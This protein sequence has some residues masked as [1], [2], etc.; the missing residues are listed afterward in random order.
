LQTAAA[1]GSVN[2]VRFLL[3]DNAAADEV[4]PRRSSPL[5]SAIYGRAQKNVATVA[6]MLLDAGADPNV[7]ARHNGGPVLHRAVANGDIDTTRLL[8]DRGADPNAQDPVGKTPIHHAVAKNQK[9]VKLLLAHSCDTTIQSNA[10]ETPMDTA[11]RLKKK[12]VIA[13]LTD[14]GRERRRM[15]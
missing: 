7:D 5:A 8:L 13:I 4:T 1:A 15:I 10:G 11:R 14:L 3:E 12:G 2:V 6:V 9:L